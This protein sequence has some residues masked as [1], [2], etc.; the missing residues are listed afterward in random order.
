M[1]SERNK[2]MKR[3]TL[4]FVLSFVWLWAAPPVSIEARADPLPLRAGASA[5]DISPVEFPAIVN[6]NMTAVQATGVVQPL[7]ARA[8]VLE[9]G[10]TR[11]ALV[12]VDSC[13]LPRDL[14]DE[15]KAAAC[16]PTGIPAKNMMISATHTHTAPAAGGAL[17]T[18]ADPKYV[19]LLKRKLVEALEQAAG[20]L[21]PAEVGWAVVPAPEHTATRRWIF[22]PGYVRNDPFGQP[23]VRANMH[24]GHQSPDAT[25]PA[26]PIDPDLTLLSVRA[27]DGRPIALL[28]N[29]SMHYFAV[30]VQPISCDYFGLFAQQVEQELGHRSQGHPPFVAIMSHGT[31]GDIWWKDYFKPPYNREL[32]EYTQKMVRLALDGYGGISHRSDA[33]L[34]MA[35]KTLKLKRRVPNEQRLAWA[36]QIV[37]KLGDRPP[38]TLEEIYA[39]EQ[40]FLHQDPTAELKLQAIR[41]GDSGITA[42]PNEVY[43]LTGL[44]LK[45]LSPLRPTMNIELANGSEGYIPPPEQ[46][47][48]GG[49]NTWP[50]RSAGLEAQAEPKIVK[51][52][53]KLLEQVSGKPRRPFREQHGPY[54]TAVLNADPMAYWRMGEFNGPT[55]RDSGKGG[56]DGRYEEFVVFGLP[57]PQVEAF[58]GKGHVNRSPHFAGGRMAAK[59]PASA[60]RY[61]VELWFWAGMEHTFRPVTGYL[62]SRGR[63]G[64]ATGDH[65]GIGGTY[66]PQLQGKLFFTT[67]DLTAGPLIGKTTIQRWAWHH[68]VMV[69]DGQQ[70]SLYL[71]GKPEASGTVMAAL[72]TDAKMF[73]IGGRSDNDS[74]FPGKIDEAAV[75][76]R[77]LAAAEIAAH[78][79]AASSVADKTP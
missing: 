12:V 38:K 78:Y 72:A 4:G 74:N 77:A 56:H 53:L 58:S 47:P 43:A 41:I 6:G 46:H 28:G 23:T 70:V 25:G 32:G 26:G 36:R 37:D 45:A 27:R 22:R 20:R 30:G 71:D 13:M 65:V 5:V 49:Y 17:G 33:T 29:Y 52:V 48:L 14:L 42:I 63:D 15:V 76:G 60:Q 73:F 61:S 64:Q 31:S 35:Q 18:D 21:E 7:H 54:A 59:T 11:L 75:Y 55:A 66:S 16:G 1:F 19:P 34:A 2:V 62:F 69:R 24:P 50:A 51:S 39:R 57:G 68:L 10:R 40:I 8:I 44:K 67:G 9:Q 3:N 79:D